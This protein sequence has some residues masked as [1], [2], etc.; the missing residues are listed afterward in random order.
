MENLKINFDLWKKSNPQKSDKQINDL[1][2]NT[3]E[4]KYKFQD[5]VIIIED[6]IGT[7]RIQGKAVKQK[8][9]LKN[10][11]DEC[12]QLENQIEFDPEDAWLYGV[13]E[14]E[15]NDVI[16]YL[17]EQ[18]ILNDDWRK[19]GS[20]ENEWYDYRILQKINFPLVWEKY[21]YPIFKK[22]NQRGRLHSAWALMVRIRDKKCVQCGAIE[23][24]HAHHIKPFKDYEE[25]RYDVNNGVTYCADC[26]REWH[27][28]NGR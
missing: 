25:L 28:E 10:K 2:Q 13:N 26:H 1:I 12:G 27:K 7:N 17:A 4:E 6:Y 21:E 16:K 24:L 15:K 18:T 9:F 23:D 8:V 11:V 5:W 14:Y 20:K 3:F 22:T 19:K